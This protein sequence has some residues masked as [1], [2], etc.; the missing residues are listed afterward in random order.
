MWPGNRR[1]A[2]PAVRD[3]E[4]QR[5]AA[6][7]SAASEHHRTLKLGVKLIKMVAYALERASVLE[8]IKIAVI[9]EWS[10]HSAVS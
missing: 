1:G 6:G 9:M 8:A 7:P 5:A 2:W 4:E 10:P 3:C